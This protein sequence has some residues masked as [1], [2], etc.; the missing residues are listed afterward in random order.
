MTNV[1]LGCN[2][3]CLNGRSIIHN[4]RTTHGSQAQEIP[5][6]RTKRLMLNINGTK[7]W[8]INE[9]SLQSTRPHISNP[10]ETVSVTFFQ[11]I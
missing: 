7:Q 3:F 6:T 9:T 10:C 11:H 4:S 5:H 2:N 1:L 8:E